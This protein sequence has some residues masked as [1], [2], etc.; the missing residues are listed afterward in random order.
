MVSIFSHPMSHVFIALQAGIPT[1]V[2]GMPGCAKTQVHA[3]LARALGRRFVPLIGSQCTPEDVAGLPVPDHVKFLCRMMPLSWTEALLT[4]GGLLFL[5]EFG[6]VSPSVH[7]ALLT[8]VEG[9]RVG[10][11]HLDADT[12]IAA[13]MN[14]TEHSPNGTPLSLPTQN[15]FFHAKWQNDIDGF[16]SGLTT[17]EWD[18]PTLPVV[19]VDWKQ[20]IPKWG[21]IVSSFLRRNEGIIN[22][23]PADDLHPAYPTERSWR[24]TVHCLAAAD[25]TG[26]DMDTDT[27]NVRLMVE[28]NV[29]DVATSQFCNYKATLD[30]VDPLDLLDGKATFAHRAERPDLTMTVLGAVATAV[31]TASTFTPD[32]WDA[33]AIL[34]GEVGKQAHPEIALRYT[35]VLLEATGKFK[36]A[37]SAKVLKPLAELN[38]ALK[39]TG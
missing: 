14:P 33:A 4:P 9:K 16:L 32:R 24:N 10:D 15:R 26:M 18:V 23:P 37:P 3:A 29:G 2:V 22:V 31:S 12:L 38:A 21:G 25:A 1:L 5:D 27:T 8:V 30:L 39:V 7:A 13:A 19:P 34:F 6:T 35:R 11:H 20:Y 17:C 28:G 36:H